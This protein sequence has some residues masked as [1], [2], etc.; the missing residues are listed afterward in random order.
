MDR[1]LFDREARWAAGLDHIRNHVRQELVWRQLGQHLPPPSADIVAVDVGCGQ[2]TQAI[3]LAQAGFTV[4]GIDPSDHL[5]ELANR[6]LAEEEP[7]VRARMS[8]RPGHLDVDRGLVLDAGAPLPPADIVLCHGVLMYLPSLA[9]GIAVL[10]SLLAGGGVLSVLT[11]N[12]FGIAMRAGMRGEWADAIAGFDADTYTNQ[13]GIDGVRGDS[14]ATVLQT[15]QAHELAVEE[16]YGVRL[17]SD[18]WDDADVGSDVDVLLAAE[19]RAGRTDPY[20]QL[21][22]LTHTIA[23]PYPPPPPQ[24]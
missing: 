17:F 11:R 1:G 19:E 8:L 6:A 4:I 5:R 14:P 20:R 23:T 22:A 18:H 16:W 9:E 10:R 7:E 2:G 3:R 15:M 12:R 21:A 24:R 13:L